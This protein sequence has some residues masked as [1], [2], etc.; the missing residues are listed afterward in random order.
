MREIGEVLRRAREQRGISLA[1]AEA[2]TKIRL[3]YLAAMERGDFASLPGRPYAL[4]FLRNYARFLG[5]DAQPLVEELKRVWEPEPAGEPQY[6]VTTASKS[7]AKARP[8]KA[9]RARYWLVMVV[10]AAVLV[11]LVPLFT[12]AFWSSPAPETT[13][14]VQGNGAAA[15]AGTKAPGAAA[16]TPAAA[17]GTPVPPRP[18]ELQ[19]TIVAAKGPCWLEVVVGGQPVFQ[20]LLPLGKEMSF[21]ARESISVKF[22]DAGAVT[23]KVNGREIGPIGKRGEV[24]RRE[25]RPEGL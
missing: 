7:G 11:I 23:V 1:E 25:F 12:A 8:P 3:R 9:G 16:E 19:L 6:V 18:S 17:E 14:G 5:L 20:G 21:S 4:G 10:A 2:A 22:G 15:A 24:V 13:P